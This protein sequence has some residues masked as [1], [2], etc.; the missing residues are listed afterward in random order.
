[1]SKT[2]DYYTAFILSAQKEVRELEKLKEYF[3]KK[4]MGDIFSKSETTQA[5]DKAYDLAV[6][7]IKSLDKKVTKIIKKH[8]MK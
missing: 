3:L 8:L 5:W 6:F 4:S 2:K 1:M 7:K